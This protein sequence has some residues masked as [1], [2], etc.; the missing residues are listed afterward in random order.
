MLSKISLGLTS[1][2]CFTISFTAKTQDL[3][4]PNGTTYTTFGP[5]ETITIDYGLIKFINNCAG[6]DDDYIY[7]FADI[8]IV[9]ASSNIIIGSALIDVSGVPNTVEAASGGVFVS[10]DIGFTEPT[11]TIK[12]G[13]YSIVY[14]ECQNGIF[15]E[16]DT[17]FQNAFNVIIPITI[18]KIDTY[19]QKIKSDAKILSDHWAV[20]YL[21]H[22]AYFGGMNIIDKFSALLDPVEA[23]LYAVNDA[24]AD[25][26]SAVPGVGAADPE[27][28]VLTHLKNTTKHYYGI[29]KDPPDPDFQNLTYLEAREVIESY[30]ID[31]LS[32]PFAKL[33]TNANAEEVQLYALLKSIEKYQ[34]AELS[35]NSEWALIHARAIKMYT[36][37]LINQLW[38]TN[39]SLAELTNAIVNDNRPLDQFA[40]EFE[41]F[42]TR[43][44]DFGFTPEELQ[45]ASDLNISSF[46]L[47]EIQDSLI[48]HDTSNFSKN[49]LL[50]NISE[51][52]N[53]NNT[54]REDLNSFLSALQEIIDTFKETPQVIDNLPK[55]DAGGPYFRTEGSTISFDGSSSSSQSAIISY[56]WDFDGDNNFDDG[57]GLSPSYIYNKAFTG[58]V[59]L[60]VTDEE[61]FYNIDYAIVEISNLN[62]PPQ[63][64]NYSPFK[65][66][67]AINSGVSE[68]FSLN[69]FDSE[70]D[71]LT[72]EWYVDNVHVYTGENLSYNPTSSDVGVHVIE[73]R[74]TDNN[75]LGGSI[76]TSWIVF[77]FL[78]DLDNDSWRANVD[79]DDSDSLVNPGMH[80]IYGNG[81]DDDCNPATLDDAECRTVPQ[82]I[83][84][85]WPGDNNGSDL[86]SNRNVQLFSGAGYSSGISG[87]AFS[88]DGV[89][90]VIQIPFDAPFDFYYGNSITIEAWINA[91]SIA[92]PAGF[93]SYSGPILTKGRD[94][95]R[96]NWWFGISGANGLAKLGFFYYNTSGAQ[97]A[98]FSTNSI[99]K[100]STWYHVAVSYSFGNSASMKIFVDGQQIAGSW[101][102]GTGN[103]S[104]A[105]NNFFPRIGGEEDQYANDRFKGYIDEVSIY[106]RTFT[107]SEIQLIFLAGGSGKCKNQVLPDEDK[108]G[109]TVYRGDHD[110]SNSQIYPGAPE[111]CDGLD[112]DCDG[113]I[114]EGADCWPVDPNCGGLCSELF[115]S[116]VPVP[117]FLAISPGGQYGDYMYAYS[118]EDN[119]IYRISPEGTANLFTQLGPKYGWYS[120]LAFDNT[121]DRRYGGYLYL[122][123]DDNPSGPCY[124][125]IYRILPDCTIEPFVDGCVGS[126]ILRGS[127]DVKI[128]D[129]GKFGF[130]F[131]LSDFELENY[132]SPSNIMQIAPWGGRYPFESVIL[133]GI[134]AMDFDRFGK[135]QGDLI[136]ANKSEYEHECQG[137]NVIYRI[138]PD[139]GKSVLIPD[140][141]LGRTQDVTVDAVGTFNGDLFVLY[142]NHV[143]TVLVEYNQLGQEVRRLESS[144]GGPLVQDRWGAFNYGIYYYAGN[145]EIRRLICSSP[146]ISISLSSYDFGE[147]TMGD[148]NDQ[149][150]TI[151]NSGCP[152]VVNSI[153]I[154]GPDLTQFAIESITTP[155]TLESNHSISFMSTFCPTSLGLKNA[156]LRISSND[157]NNNQVDMQM[158]GNCIAEVPPDYMYMRFEL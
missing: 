19:I 59:G 17:I 107:A 2:L 146:H 144:V 67:I 125:G 42:R 150:L 88:V 14:D 151:S 86:I 123:V 54:F 71:V 73:V 26:I 63:I 5:N 40:Q 24:I 137:N 64:I 25:G 1:V 121:P 4:W 53:S 11:G 72:K 154:L 78:P 139:G 48:V 70:G 94:N 47:S 103:E 38:S 81:K 143:S 39:A 109:F 141:G 8:Y 101:T 152:L 133:R 95:D 32:M 31:V 15:D 75:I 99:I 147:L 3:L 44:R 13:L 41:N 122:T 118:W 114:D 91:T 65:G 102:A 43:I 49:G 130:G 36:E 83:L 111:L 84:A 58:Y 55:A 100:T 6:G 61:G 10:E 34:G 129:H 140:R 76:I 96:R 108:D 93:N 9:P 126:P 104:P 62:S 98:Y 45:I 119:C 80:E 117:H 116:A 127:Y 85:W 135:F 134:Y 136:A 115:T 56:Q 128:D 69:A 149:I 89:D 23:L 77:V 20:N 113:T 120:D 7:P 18:P 112:N 97:Q 131:F 52:Q 30:S 92:I 145:N 82:G 68:T 60:K 22:Y 50:S 132:G 106:N 79:C 90:D 66:G 28:A 27:D 153:E 37:L 46:L 110:D 156:I 51:L 12:A 105:L 35:N 33:G 87:Q 74:I 148:H 29:Y 157:P 138:K 21:Y 124:D 16:E 142:D 155:F 158:H 57:V